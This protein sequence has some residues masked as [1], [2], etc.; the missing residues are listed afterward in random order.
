MFDFFPGDYLA[1][2]T[3]AARRIV[4]LAVASGQRVW[5]FRGVATWQF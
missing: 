2:S 1:C 4:W 5:I 3:P